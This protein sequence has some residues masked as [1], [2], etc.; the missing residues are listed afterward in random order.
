MKAIVLSLYYHDYQQL[1]VP[2]TT[3]ESIKY[4]YTPT[5]CVIK[6]KMVL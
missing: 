3:V 1:A 6:F 4:S 5:F 2:G